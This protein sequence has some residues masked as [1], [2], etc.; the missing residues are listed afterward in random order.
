MR[1]ALPTDK[2]IVMR[3][4]IAVAAQKPTGHE[5]D[6]PQSGSA[7]EPAS[8][9]TENRNSIGP[10]LTPRGYSAVEAKSRPKR[11]ARLPVRS[12]SGRN[13]PRRCVRDPDAGP[14]LSGEQVGDAEHHE[15][16]QQ[17]RRQLGNDQGRRQGRVEAAFKHEFGH[18]DVLRKV[19]GMGHESADVRAYFHAKRLREALSKRKRAGRPRVEE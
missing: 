12:A 8:C 19:A 3:S 10:L 14:G 2:H 4:I 9:Q 5:S 18:E 17:E 16:E 11:R 7:Q 15:Q 6:Q 13:R 1:S